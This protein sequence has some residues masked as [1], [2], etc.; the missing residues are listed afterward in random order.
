MP[1]SDRHAYYDLRQRRALQRLP[2]AGATG[3]SVAR[4]FSATITG[5]GAI[6]SF[7]VTHNFGT[8]DVDVT[9]YLNSGL[10]QEVIPTKQHTSVNAVTIVFGVAPGAGVTHRVVVQG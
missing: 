3:T 6:T 10:F 8:R 5:N 7:I 9:V 2:G 1:R 4:T